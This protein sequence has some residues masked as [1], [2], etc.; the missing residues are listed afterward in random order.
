MLSEIQQEATIDIR[1]AGQHHGETRHEEAGPHRSP[2][3]GIEVIA[4]AQL[5][6]PIFVV[7]IEPRG[8]MIIG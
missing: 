8:K 3:P 6:E 2:S 1:R 5:D 7:S 4:Y